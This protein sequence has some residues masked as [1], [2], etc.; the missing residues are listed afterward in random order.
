MLTST[1]NRLLLAVALVLFLGL[2]HP[3]ITADDGS[4]GSVNRFG[5]ALRFAEVVFP[6][7]KGK[8]LDV[9]LS[10]GNGGF[11]NSASEMDDLQLRFDKPTWHPPGET[12]EKLDAM[13]TETMGKG[14]IVLPFYLYFSFIEMRQPVLP[15]RLACRPVNFTSDAGHEQMR[16]AQEAI[17]SHPEWSDAQEL[18]EARKLGL[19]YGPEDKDAVLR[20]ISIKELSQFY[21]P[22]KIKSAV[23]FMNGGGKCAGCSF[24]LPRWEVKASATRDVR[25]LSITI[26]PFFGRIT[27]LSSGE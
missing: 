14:G 15:R 20:L 4:C 13:L 23:F 10:H 11:L 8:E 19:R 27:S 9:S 18:E 2:L 21:G 26:E 1:Q 3:P 22:L 17:E 25:W 12:N 16:K 7:L 5:A 24:V 6:E